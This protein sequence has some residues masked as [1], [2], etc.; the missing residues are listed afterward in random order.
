VRCLLK[1]QPSCPR[2][3]PTKILNSEIFKIKDLFTNK[4][5]AHYS[6][7]SLCW[8]GKRTGE[9]M[10]SSTTWY[11]VIKQLGLKRIATRI[12]PEK[13]KVGIRASA[14]CQIWH[15]DFTI[16][17]L[18]DGTKA[19][20]QAVIDNFSRYVLAWNVS[21]DYGGLNTKK[22]LE[23]AISKAK[24]FGF[25]IVPNVFVDSGSEN[26]NK[27]VDALVFSNQITRTIAQ[28]DVDQSNSMIEMLFHRMKHRHLFRVPL[29]NLDV[30]IKEVDFYINED[31]SA[32]PKSILKGATP[33]EVMLGKWTVDKINLIKEKILETK[34]SRI[35]KNMEFKCQPCNA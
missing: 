7:Q 5:F 33:E 32:I 6:I 18:Q 17:K 20:I 35:Q 28:I 14:P 30:L 24:S 3:S 34:A 12:Y 10:T 19:Y 26:L 31:N 29:T 1:D 27:Y 8:L 9:V 25:D 13:S 11:R 22:L 15:L 23:R 2:V 21:P 16:L 4:S